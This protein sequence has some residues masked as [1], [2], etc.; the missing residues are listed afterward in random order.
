MPFLNRVFLVFLGCFIAIIMAFPP[1]PKLVTS[2]DPIFDVKASNALFFHNI[3]SFYY[4][5]KEWPERKMIGFNHKKT[6]DHP[7]QIMILQHQINQQI[8][9]RLYW[10]DSVPNTAL[11]INQETFFLE[12]KN[13]EYHWQAGKALYH[14]LQNEEQVFKLSEH[15]KEILYN[16]EKSK[17][18]AL[19][20][21]YDY[22][23][24]VGH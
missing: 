1:G 10:L 8:Y 24:A 12:D 16:D 2:S 6:A 20:V 3:R 14:S 23:H 21:L 5:R 18:K 19:E 13:S 22:F 11:I 17:Q 4:E 7:L 15:K 9:L